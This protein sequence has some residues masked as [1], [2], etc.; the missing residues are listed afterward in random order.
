MVKVA[1][2]GH[3]AESKYFLYYFLNWSAIIQ[4]VPMVRLGNSSDNFCP[5]STNQACAG[6]IGIEWYMWKHLN[7]FWHGMDQQPIIINIII[8]LVIIMVW[9]PSSLCRDGA[10]LLWIRDYNSRPGILFIVIKLIMIMCGGWACR[11]SLKWILSV[12]RS[13]WRWCGVGHPT[14]IPIVNRTIRGGIQL[15]K[16]ARHSSFSSVLW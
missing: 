8:F 13:W 12:R 6:V 15:R 10:G 14:Q 11:Y 4:T 7:S 16:H 1:S 2:L 3:R 5:N 9:W